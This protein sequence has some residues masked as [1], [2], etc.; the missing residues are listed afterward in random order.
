MN[1]LSLGDENV[2][3]YS[4]HKVFQLQRMSEVSLCMMLR[5]AVVFRCALSFWVSNTAI[6]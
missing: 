1:E 2:A 3:L 5:V 4:I 6:Q